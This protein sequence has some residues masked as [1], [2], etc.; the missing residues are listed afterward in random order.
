MRLRLSVILL[1][2]FPVTLFA[3]E[4]Q[5]IDCPDGFDNRIQVQYR[6]LSKLLYDG[7]DGSKDNL[8]YIFRLTNTYSE[9]Q[10]VWVT[11][12]TQQG[13]GS[14]TSKNG[15]VTLTPGKPFVDSSSVEAYGSRVTG[16]RI[17]YRPPGSASRPSDPGHGTPVA[18]GVNVIEFPGSKP[19]P[20]PRKKP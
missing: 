19:K 6:P 1:S 3:Q 16:C 10:K 17:T 9:T 5:T 7:L 13:D 15:P 4:W 20:K 2:I 8:H 11:V 12:V 14:Q 18:P